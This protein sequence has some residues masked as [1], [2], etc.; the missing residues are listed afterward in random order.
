MKNYTPAKGPYEEHLF[1]HVEILDSW[2]L[3]K[4]AETFAVNCNMT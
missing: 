3:L 2:G 1:N 4:T